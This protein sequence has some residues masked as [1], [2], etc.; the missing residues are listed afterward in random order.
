MLEGD[1]GWVLSAVRPVRELISLRKYSNVARR[2][3]SSIS[4]S[5]PSGFAT[6]NGSPMLRMI[7]DSPIRYLRSHP[8]RDG[9]TVF[10]LFL[11][12]ARRAGIQS[13]SYGHKLATTSAGGRM[14]FT[15]YLIG[16]IVLIVGLAFGANM[17]HVAPRWIAVGAI[18][19]TG[20]GIVT[21]VARTRQRD[22]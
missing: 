17:M 2:R 15:L 11:R 6:G 22:P 14:S 18:I 20:F 4:A 7:P 9:G 13:I 10:S 21:G 19:L 12:G 1:P 3:P 8:H 5:V 16:F